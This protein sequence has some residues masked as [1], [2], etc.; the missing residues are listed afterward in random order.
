MKVGVVGVGSL[1]RHHARIVASIPSVTLA[2]VCD[3]DFDRC[4]HW[5]QEYSAKAYSHHS[6]LAGEVDAVC[7]AVP[8]VDHHAICADLLD[9][10]KHVLVEKPISVTLGE[11]EDM[12]RRA[13]KAGG[14]L[15]VGHLERFNPAFLAVR[16]MISD[17]KFFEVHRLGVFV[18]RS[19]DIDVVLDLMIHDI[20]MMLSL[21]HSPIRDLRAVG[22]PILTDKIDIANVRMEFENGAVANLTASRVSSEK[23]RKVRFF[24]KDQYISINL[25]AQTVNVFELRTSDGPFGKEISSRNIMVEH[26][27]P[28]RNEI[29]AFLEC[30]R[31]GARPACSGR[32]GLAALSAAHRVLSAMHTV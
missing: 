32:E 1:G 21:V 22:I 12:V 5:A 15:Q 8:T 19:L 9:A 11:G 4:R 28:L 31:T 7:V 24:Q 26:G 10:G 14:V 27:E 29:L 25:A 16:P 30:A 6:E 3:V 23:T 2:G 17:P 18:P 20:D 13:E